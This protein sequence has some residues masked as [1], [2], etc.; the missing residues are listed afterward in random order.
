MDWTIK[1]ASLLFLDFLLCQFQNL[2]QY[3]L[4]KNL[5]QECIVLQVLPSK[6]YGQSKCSV[7]YKVTPIESKIKR[8][9]KENKITSVPRSFIGI[10]SQEVNRL[11]D[12]KGQLRP[13]EEKNSRKEYPLIEWGINQLDCENLIKSA[14]LP[15]PPKSSCF[16][17]PNRK[18][19]EVIELKEKHPDL[20]ERAVFLEENAQLR[21]IKGLGRTWAWGDLD[22]MTPLE[23]VL[24]DSQQNSR[25]CACID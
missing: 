11:L 5:E 8:W 13:L 6:A 20:Y 10:H 25:S 12:K 14:G 15:L 22:K 9:V 19:S 24:F 2:G 3:L 7:K 21:Q 17:C 18:L 23:Q 4:Y 1:N 16:F